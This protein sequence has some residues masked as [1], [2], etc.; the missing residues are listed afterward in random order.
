MASGRKFDFSPKNGEVFYCQNIPWLITNH[1]KLFDTIF[2]RFSYVFEN[3]LKKLVKYN[4]FSYNFGLN[5][6]KTSRKFQKDSNFV[7]L[8]R[9]TDTELDAKNCHKIP[10][11]PR[12]SHGRAKN[13]VLNPLDLGLKM[14]LHEKSWVFPQTVVRFSLATLLGLK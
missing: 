7:W 1:V 9:I 2:R 4:L 13:G 12:L 3:L 10:M 11:C 6:T 14:A 8:H 5:S